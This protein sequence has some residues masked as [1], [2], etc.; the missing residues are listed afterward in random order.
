MQ[1][2][3]AIRYSLNLADMAV[4]RALDQVQDIP[5]TFPT[6]Q[7]GCHPL[8]V[9]GHLAVIEG[10]T[11][12]ILTGRP[13]PLAKWNELFG[14]ETVASDNAGL[15]PTI[16]E[17]RARYT[18]L[19][20]ENLAFLDS[21]RESELDTPTVMQPAGVE[22]HFNTYG[23]ALLTLALHQTMHRGQLTDVFRMAGR[24]ERALAA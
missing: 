2:K 3:E 6:E 20:K 18:E 9:V 15:Y 4:M 19:R 16:A 8:W 10:M 14:Q 24:V 22:E 13:N 11:N 23:R 1:T 5:F 7:G 21:L 17:V 12:E